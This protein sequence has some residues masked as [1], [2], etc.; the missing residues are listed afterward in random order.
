MKK[1]IAAIALSSVIAATGL[2]A[3]SAGASAEWVKTDTSYSY[4]DDSTGKTLKGWQEIDGGKYYFNKDGNALKGWYKIGGKTYYFNGSKKGKMVTGKAKIGGKTYDFGTDGVLKGTVTTKSASSKSAVPYAW[5]TSHDKV[6]EG[7][8]GADKV[9]DLEMLV[10]GGDEKAMQMAVFD[11][12][13][14][15]I[16]Y[17]D[18]VEGDQ[19]ASFN[20]KLENSG[21][22]LTNTFDEDDGTAYIY[23]K[24]SDDLVA[25][26]YTDDEETKATTVIYF[27]P[28]LAKE[29]ITEMAKPDFSMSDFADYMG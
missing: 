11:E 15:L 20:K 17:A 14:K 28:E 4:K 12:D 19:T 24:G 16:L 6:V 21:Y 29:A 9:F 13:A 2:S 18:I 3:L 26:A 5:G 22:K 7:M 10:L 23:V 27:S 8:G 25:V 1:K